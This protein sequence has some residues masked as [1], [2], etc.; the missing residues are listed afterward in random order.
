MT[1]TSTIIN[2]ELLIAFLLRSGL[3]QGC[4]LYSFQHTLAILASAT[5][6]EKEKMFKDWKGKVKTLIFMDQ[7]EYVYIFKS[8][9]VDKLL[10]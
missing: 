2:G 7:I 8:Q 6:Q 10:E 9:S 5:R 3:R 4:L 1:I